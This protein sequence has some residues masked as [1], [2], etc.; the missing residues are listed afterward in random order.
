[1]GQVSCKESLTTDLRQWS[2]MRMY[3]KCQEVPLRD[4][5]E[6]YIQMIIF[7]V[8]LRTA[9]EVE[10][11]LERG[12]Q[13]AWTAGVSPLHEANDKK[14]ERRRRRSHNVSQQHKSNSFHLQ[15]I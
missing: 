2:A 13:S 8:V 14:L 6:R 7:L 1:M 5:K 15:F 10:V 11:R 4:P 9:S 3:I 12:D